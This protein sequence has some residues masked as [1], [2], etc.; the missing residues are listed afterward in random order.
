MSA[1][2]TLIVAAALQALVALCAAVPAAAAAPGVVAVH[3]LIFT[4]DILLSRQVVREIAA[5]KDASPWRALAPHFASAD[6]VVGNLEGAVGTAAEC[7]AAE[8][9][10]CFATPPQLI[11]LL[12]QAG[13]FAIGLE[14]NHSADLGEA[15][16][17]RTRE[18]L[19]AHRLTALTFED[20][21]GFLRVG[22]KTLAIIAFT[23]IAG[24]DGER[25]AIPSQ[26]LRQKLRL[27]R[28]LADWVLVYVHWGA[29]LTDWPQ[30]QQRE[31]AAWLIRQGADV[32]VGHHPHVVQPP[33]C[34][35]GRPVFF[36]LGNHVF[37]QKYPLTKEGLLAECTIAGDMLQCV[38]R[39]T[40]TPAASAFPTLGTAETS[41]CG[42][43]AQAPSTVAGYTLQLHA[44]PGEFVQGDLVMEGHGTG[45]RP[46][47]TAARRLL[48]L[49]GG[50]LHEGIDTELLFTLEAYP[51]SLDNEIGPRPYVYEVTARGLI[52]R[53]RGS[54]L[55]WP[56]VDAQL[57]RTTAGLDLVC[58][59]HRGDSFVVLNK[60]S[61]SVRTALYRWNGFGFSG[62]Q[63]QE[64]DARCRQLFEIPPI[65]EER[66][67]FPD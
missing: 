38:G 11:P 40:H 53:W 39:A 41:V 2:R 24:K 19:A 48:A 57:L 30:A 54:A 18:A 51:S 49:Q 13:F 3:R 6:W 32:I 34:V 4:G 25:I 21:P 10:L 45:S 42:A 66:N 17:A 62:V 26:A 33:E 7:A 60:D 1:P 12:K 31:Q 67:G 20:S 43:P 15:G 44:A 14:N 65:A 9:P 50:K 5:R 37:D 63:D 61:Q 58:A 36:S 56:L 55:A 47:V 52:A 16:R 23:T 29:E 8:D 27:A 28:A 59:L 35:L 46:W 64:L 22:K